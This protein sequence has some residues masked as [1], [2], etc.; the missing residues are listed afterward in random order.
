MFISENGESSSND[1]EEKTPF[2]NEIM[3]DIVIETKPDTPVR[4]EPD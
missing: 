4:E 1:G 2:R 3:K